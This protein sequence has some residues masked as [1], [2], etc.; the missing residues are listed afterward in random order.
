MSQAL[1]DSCFSPISLVSVDEKHPKKK[2]KAIADA[3]MERLKSDRANGFDAHRI[4]VRAENRTKAEE[5]FEDYQQWYP[6]ERIVL[7]HSGITG[8]KKIIEDI[9]DHKYDIVVCV[10]MLK[11]GFDYPNFK[12]AAV[13]SVHKSLSVLLQFIGRFTRTQ[14][15]LGPAS[16]VVN[17]AEEKMSQEL[18]NLFQE[19][20]GWETV[21]SEIADA[22]K[23]EAESL[24][25]FLQ[26]CQPYSGF[27]SPDI[28]LNPKL[29]YPALS[30]VCYKCE[31]VNWINFK[32]AFN[33]KQY[34]LS[35][36]YFNQQ[37]NVFYFTTQKRDKVKWAKTDKI[38]DQKWDLIILH[39]DKTN[40]KSL[41]WVFRKTVGC[42]IFS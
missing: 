23:T 24:L 37:E 1:R 9:R 6:D 15:K 28:E 35:Q 36:P 7:V 12:I 25:T 3:A 38:R 5:L 30:C 26:G 27:D 22:K 19:G 11:E 40:K 13:H 18:E 20:S 16:F 8:R 14:E 21:I 4:M 41:Y 39:F 33:L 2:D 10:D 31:T 32:N 42:Q 29:V 34:A 17:Y